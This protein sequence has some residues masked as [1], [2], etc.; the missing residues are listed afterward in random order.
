MAE[1]WL[2]VT[3]GEEGFF[4]GDTPY[5][6]FNPYGV[7]GVAQGE[8]PDW[9]G[10]VGQDFVAQHSSPD[11]DFAVMHLWGDNWNNT[12][13]L[14]KIPASHQI[15]SH[16]SSAHALTQSSAK[17]ICDGPIERHLSLFVYRHRQMLRRLPPFADT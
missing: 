13:A 5:A 6:K 14:E 4:R 15:L 7:N 8:N 10:N 17:C 12:R 2:Q 1:I 16:S 9:A 11:I 3:T